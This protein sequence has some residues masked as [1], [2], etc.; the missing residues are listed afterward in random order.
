MKKIHILGMIA[1]SLL[2]VGCNNDKPAFGSKQWAEYL[3]GPERNHYST[4]EQINPANVKQLQVAWQ[5]RTLDSG[6]IQCN[7]IVVDS[8]LYGMTATTEPFALNAATG[9][10]IWRVQSVNAK[11][12]A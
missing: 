8:I 10:E 11:R 4:L 6:Q 3:G 7:P 1:L 9:K 5:Y 2:A 12:I